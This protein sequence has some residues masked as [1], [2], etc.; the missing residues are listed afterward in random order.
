MPDYRLERR[1]APLANGGTIAGIDE[2]GRGPLA[3]P[4][5]AAAL[6]LDWKRLPRPL[7]SAIDDSKALVRE[8]RENIFAAL[9]KAAAAGIVRFAVGMASVDEINSINILQATF[10]AMQRAVEGLEE[11]PA[12]ALI[13]GNQAPRLPC[14]I[15]TIIDGDALCISIAAASI[16]AK[17]TRDRIMVA[18]A[19]EHPG[20]G[21]DTNVGYS[22]RAH[23]AGLARLGP[24][25]H[26]RR[27]FAPVRNC[28]NS[29]VS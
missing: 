19:D 21:W 25:R 2:A 4:V 8:R 28:L 11:V 17:V 9:E 16:V 22:T 1:F 3:G 13:D 7:K 6:V 20:Y 24:T 12:L 23:Y 14:Q 18:L 5:V 29:T 27:S 15:Q 26:H 10:R